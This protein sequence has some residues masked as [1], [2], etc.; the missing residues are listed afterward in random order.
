MISPNKSV[1]AAE[2][3]NE[4]AFTSDDWLAS[5]GP[6]PGQS[7]K[8]AS[9]WAC[10]NG[11]ERARGPQCVDLLWMSPAELKKAYGGNPPEVGSWMDHGSLWTMDGEHAAY[12]SQPYHLSAKAYSQLAVIERERDVLVMVNRTPSWHYPGRAI[13]IELW[14]RRFWHRNLPTLTSEPARRG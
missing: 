2:R 9:D 1:G 6:E 11:L 7:R 10:A 13:M 5:Q 12:V 8:M 4:S 3:L 14:V